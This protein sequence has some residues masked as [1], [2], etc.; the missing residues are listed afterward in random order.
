MNVKPTA[1]DLRDIAS[2]LM[3]ESDKAL[4]RTGQAARLERLAGRV[5][6]IADDMDAEA[7]A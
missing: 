6:A 7:T 4:G 5:A 3:S 1:L 2:E